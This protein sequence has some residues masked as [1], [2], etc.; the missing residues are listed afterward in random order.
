MASSLY[1]KCL[2]VYEKSGQGGVFDLITAN[3][4]DTRWAYCEPCEIESPLEDGDCLVC[5][6]IIREDKNV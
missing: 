6:S 2:E 3:F 1:G 4:P 5:G